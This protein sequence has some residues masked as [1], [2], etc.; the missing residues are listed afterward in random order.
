MRPAGCRAERY[1][2]DAEHSIL[3]AQAHLP[4]LHRPLDVHGNLLPTGTRAGQR[5]CWVSDARNG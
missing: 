2:H 3:V 1:Q 5:Q 4:V